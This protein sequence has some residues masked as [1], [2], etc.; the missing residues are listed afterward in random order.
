MTNP[1]PPRSLTRVWLGVLAIVVLALIVYIV[2]R[3]S[4]APVETRMD[5]VPTAQ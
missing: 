2:T 5:S 4:T 1:S 3:P